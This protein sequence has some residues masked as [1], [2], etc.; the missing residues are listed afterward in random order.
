VSGESHRYLRNTAGEEYVLGGRGPDEHVVSPEEE[1]TRTLRE[2]FEARVST[3]APPPTDE[4][5]TPSS[6][7][8]S[9]EGQLEDLGYL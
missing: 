2:Q 4:A 8:R 3:L 1:V 9:V 5:E 6:L 7:G